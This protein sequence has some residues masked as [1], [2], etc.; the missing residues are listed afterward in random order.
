MDKSKIGVKIGICLLMTVQFTQSLVTPGLA[1]MQQTFSDAPVELVQSL[2]TIATLFMF[3]SIFVGPG[4]RKIGY[5]RMTIL[6]VALMFV[7]ALGVALIG[8]ANFWGVFVSR[9]IYG[10]GY[11]FAFALCIA[12]CG[13]LYEGRERSTMLGIV[14]GVGGLAAIIFGYVAGIL[15]GINWVASFWFMAAFILVFGIVS[16]ILLPEP[17]AH[18]EAARE[19]TASAHKQKLPGNFWFMIIMCM[20]GIAAFTSFMNNAAMVILGSGLGD[21]VALGT[22]FSAMGVGMMVGSFAY[23]PIHRLL[24]NFTHPLILILMSLSYIGFI[25]AT[26]MPVFIALAILFGFSFGL[27]N[28][29]WED[30]LF[31][32]AGGNSANVSSIFVATQGVGQ[33]VSP[34]ML[35][36]LAT[37]IGITGLYY[38]WDLVAPCISVAAIV[39]LVLN[40]ISRVV[41]PKEATATSDA[42]NCVKE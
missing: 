3:A 16:I 15:S 27:I 10:I 35:G 26:N 33:F 12:Y 11:G 1:A 31:E 4:I 21:P 18:P 41:K 30:L 9:I 8:G 20:L 14:S 32:K 34:T 38:Q 25:F 37:G 23:S 29:C 17:A 19:E 6:T 5:R 2:S 13:A 36:A 28:P 24:Q 39:V 40:I 7:G 22:A 42:D